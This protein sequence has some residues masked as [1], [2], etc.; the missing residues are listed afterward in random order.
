MVE[1]LSQ[2]SWLGIGLGA[3]AI[4][5]TLLLYVLNGIVV[6]GQ[7]HGTRNVVVLC[8]NILLDRLGVLMD[9]LRGI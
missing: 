1:L 2:P 5:V 9:V 8:S 4:M 6:A 7:H 3:L